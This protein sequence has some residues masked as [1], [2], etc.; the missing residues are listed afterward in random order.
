HDHRHGPATRPR[1]SAGSVG[2]VLFPADLLARALPGPAA[3]RPGLPGRV[4]VP[5]PAAA[6]AARLARPDA[7]PALPG[8]APPSPPPTVGPPSPLSRPLPAPPPPPPPARGV[9]GGRLP[10]A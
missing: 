5:R 9:A 7:D 2:A 8:A 3:A 4:P 1:R 10:L 6:A